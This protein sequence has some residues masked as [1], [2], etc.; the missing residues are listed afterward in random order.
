[1][2]NEK[3]NNLTSFFNLEISRISEDAT[4]LASLVNVKK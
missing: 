3:G 4:K 2:M 1:M